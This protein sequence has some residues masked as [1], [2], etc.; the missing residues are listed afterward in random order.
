MISC[1]YPLTPNRYQEAPLATWT[2]KKGSQ[3]NA[4]IMLN[5]NAMNELN[6][7]TQLFRLPKELK[8]I[9]WSFRYHARLTRS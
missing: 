1:G 5:A 2:A 3:R 7:T 9:L 8:V 6:E 4:L